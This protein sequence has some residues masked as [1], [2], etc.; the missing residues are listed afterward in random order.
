M[1]NGVVSIVG[2]LGR[3]F[4]LLVGKALNFR[5]ISGRRLAD[6]GKTNRPF[7][8]TGVATGIHG[9]KRPAGVS[10]ADPTVR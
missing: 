3:V 10:E 5:H 1:L 6:V 2:S 7:K 8:S 9:S 4:P